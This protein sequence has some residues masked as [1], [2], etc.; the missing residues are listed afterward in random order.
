[1]NKIVLFL[2]FS[3]LNIKCFFAFQ[4]VNYTPSPV[5]ES[6]KSYKDH[7][8]KQCFD[9]R[10]NELINTHFKMPSDLEG[11]YEGEVKILFEVTDKGFFKVLHVSSDEL[12][13][14]TAANDMFESFPRVTPVTHNGEPTYSQ[15]SVSLKLPLPSNL[16]QQITVLTNPKASE[17]LKTDSEYDLVNEQLI[18][19]KYPEYHSNL[20]IPFSHDIYSK[21]DA[22]MNAVGT[23]THTASKPYVYNDVSNYYDFWNSFDHSKY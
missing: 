18:P 11:H 3:F 19:Y 5:F 2:I 22:A 9:S 7:A 4:S 17:S 14:K 20:Q 12:S 15:F 21:F 23:N 8:L 6:C 10:L 1:M 13:L 16:E